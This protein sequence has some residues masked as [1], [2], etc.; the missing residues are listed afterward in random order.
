MTTR[1]RRAALRRSCALAALAGFLAANL[2]PQSIVVHHH[3]GDALPH[4]HPFG[5]FTAPAHLHVHFHAAALGDGRPAISGPGEGEHVHSQQ[6]YQT[7][8]RPDVPGL[9]PAAAVARVVGAAVQALPCPASL[10][11]RSRGPPVPSSA[12]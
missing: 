12:V 11:P 3:P 9:T 4:V 5:T 2:V 10:D 1:R 8:A 6:P 7:A